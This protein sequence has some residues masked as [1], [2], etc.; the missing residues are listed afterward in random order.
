[1]LGVME[2]GRTLGARALVLAL[3]ALMACHGAAR[4]AAPI[5]YAGDAPSARLASGRVG[6]TRLASLTPARAAA[7]PL[8]P[9]LPS[10]GYGAGAEVASGPLIDLRGALPPEPGGGDARP[11]S[12]RQPPAETPAPEAALAP[13]GEGQEVGL[14][15]WYGDEFQGRKTASG[16]PFDAEALTA[17]HPTLPLPSLARVTNLAN[18]KEIVVRVNDRGPF[19]GDRVIDVSRRGAELLDFKEAGHARVRVT[20]LGPASAGPDV[21]ANPD[22]APPAAALPE[23]PQKPAAALGE[24]YYVQIGAFAAAENAETARR[25]AADMGDA[26]VTPVAAAGRALYRVRLGPWPD[27]ATAEAA[28][29][30]AV[31][32]GFAGARIA[33]D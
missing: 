29:A 4:A 10:Y 26:S 20:Y 14:A 1:M 9:L 33:R 12:V 5:V 6:E 31:A 18:G 17:A 21:A 16:E 15:S 7:P 24:G 8:K 11:A 27:A 23:P 32:K 22:T 25:R 19:H 3:L 13:A 28:R 30:A 2:G